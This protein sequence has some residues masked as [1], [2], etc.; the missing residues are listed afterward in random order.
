MK[1]VDLSKIRPESVPTLSTIVAEL[2]RIVLDEGAS[3][4]AQSSVL[5]LLTPFVLDGIAQA[6]FFRSRIIGLGEPGDG[7]PDCNKCGTH[8]STRVHAAERTWFTRA[9]SRR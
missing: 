7:G 9:A 3:W 1:P 5:E 8:T 2:M 4:V 6:P